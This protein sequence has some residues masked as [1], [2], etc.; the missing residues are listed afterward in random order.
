MSRSWSVEDTADNSATPAQAVPDRPA[1]PKAATAV[2]KAWLTWIA[3]RHA[4]APVVFGKGDRELLAAEPGNK[5]ARPYAILRGSGEGLDHRVADGVAETVVDLLEAI[6]V[7]Q[8]RRHRGAA[9]RSASDRR[10]TP[11]VKGATVP[12]AGQCVGEGGGAEAALDPL[13]GEGD[14]EEGE[15]LDEDHGFERDDAVAAALAIHGIYAALRIVAPMRRA[16]KL[17]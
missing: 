15:D 3:T 6:E 17:S 7:E 2:S 16:S 5:I 10:F 4:S 9:P 11:F 8:D 12:E 13:L 14:H 1:G